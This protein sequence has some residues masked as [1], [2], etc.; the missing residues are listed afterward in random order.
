M[1]EWTNSELDRLDTTPVNDSGRVEIIGCEGR[2][3][4]DSNHMAM[5]ILRP[6]S[7]RRA[8]GRS[9]F[10]VLKMTLDEFAK[11]SMAIRDRDR[12]WI[13]MQEVSSRPY[14]C[15]GW[16]ASNDQLIESLVWRGL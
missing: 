2:Y 14:D 9:R 11:S 5:C 10:H 7:Q 16:K 6:F 4:I 8:A 13:V 3:V 15:V 1:L 12:W